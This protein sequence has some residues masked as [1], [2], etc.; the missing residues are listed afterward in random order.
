[1]CFWDLCLRRQN[2]LGEGCQACPSRFECTDT[3]RATLKIGRT[4]GLLV[5]IFSYSIAEQEDTSL[6]VWFQDRPLCLKTIRI[7]LFADLLEI[8]RASNQG[9]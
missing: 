5:R 1:M 6:P 7:T 8:R 4:A 2:A 3:R 9:I